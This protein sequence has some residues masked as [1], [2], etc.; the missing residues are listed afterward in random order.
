MQ[1]ID[2]N[3]EFWMT[4][5]GI[6]LIEEEEEWDAMVGDT[7][8]YF[9]RYTGLEMM[10]LEARHPFNARGRRSNQFITDLII[11][12]MKRWDN[13]KDAAGKAV[14]YHE[15]LAQY[16]PEQDRVKMI[17]HFSKCNP[18]GMTHIKHSRIKYRRIPPGEDDRLID[19]HTQRGVL[20]ERGLVLDVMDY[21]IL[22]W[23][24]VYQDNGQE[25]DFHDSLIMQIP[26]DAIPLIG[27]HLRASMP[28]RR[29]LEAKQLGNFGP[30]STARLQTIASTASSADA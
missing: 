24:Q 28:E 19:K 17:P 25:A 30:G 22:G 26:D 9:R 7:K 10:E 1:L 5:P 18:S 2:T 14:E 20:D 11:L 16:V 12:C 21:C 4:V 3:E 6:I 27:E 29:A 23:E 8:I 13:V 15:G